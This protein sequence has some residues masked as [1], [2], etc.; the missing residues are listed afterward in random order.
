MDIFFFY[1]LLFAGEVRLVRRNIADMASETVKHVR[2]AC[3]GGSM[4]LKQ[5]IFKNIF[6]NNYYCAS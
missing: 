3:V 6:Q 1:F 4:T 2:S 5:L